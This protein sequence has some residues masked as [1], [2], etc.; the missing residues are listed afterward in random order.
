[1]RMKE[2]HPTSRLHSIL[3]IF[4]SMIL[5]INA[6]Y[7]QALKFICANH[8]VLRPIDDT[9]LLGALADLTEYGVFVGIAIDISDGYPALAIDHR[10]LPKEDR[11]PAGWAVYAYAFK[12]PFTFDRCYST[13]GYVLHQ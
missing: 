3:A 13:A 5:H 6:D 7:F 12:Q 11:L 9:I 8:A 4:N 10:L 2:S 1:M